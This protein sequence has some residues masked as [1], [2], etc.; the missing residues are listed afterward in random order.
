MYKFIKNLTKPLHFLV[1]IKHSLEINYLSYLQINI[2]QET[3]GFVKPIKEPL[4]S[5]VK[6]LYSAI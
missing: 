4:S 3:T 2:L 1:F 5:K 6:F